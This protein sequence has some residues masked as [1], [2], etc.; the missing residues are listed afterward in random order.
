MATA[1]KPKIE[2]YRNR[3]LAPM[4]AIEIDPKTKKPIK[5]GNKCNRYCKPL[6]K[7]YLR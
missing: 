5:K 4:G 6:R 3:M 2:D 1:K 7:R